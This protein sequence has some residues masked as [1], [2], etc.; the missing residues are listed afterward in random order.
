MGKECI[1]GSA[2]VDHRSE[3]V[4]KKRIIHMIPSLWGSGRA[5]IRFPSIAAFPRWSRIPS[6]PQRWETASASS[7]PVCLA[8]ADPNF[9]TSPGQRGASPPKVSATSGRKAKPCLLHASS[10]PS[11]L[12]LW[13][14]SKAKP[15]A[16]AAPG[17]V[18]TF[19]GG[20]TLTSMAASL[21]PVQL[22]T[23][24][25]A[26]RRSLPGRR[27]R[28][29]LTGPGL[30]QLLFRKLHPLGRC[31]E[32]CV[33]HQSQSRVRGL[34]EHHSPAGMQGRG[35]VGRRL[36]TQGDTSPQAQTRQGGGEALAR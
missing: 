13:A 11:S 25:S 21:P 33:L 3:T 22:G 32:L 7:C 19:M 28:P 1:S 24:T 35:H 5:G 18:V 26:G 29:S 4:E 27:K 16:L 34:Q 36:A 6:L 20:V 30:L 31:A 10:A 23:R 14:W 12:P 15:A 8:S 2:H 9:L 17:I